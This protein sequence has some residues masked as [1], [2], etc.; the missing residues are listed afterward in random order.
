MKHGIYHLLWLLAVIIFIFVGCENFRLTKTDRGPAIQ[1]HG[2]YSGINYS[3]DMQD[4]IAIVKYYNAAKN[5]KRRC[6]AEKS[7]PDCKIPDRT[8]KSGSGKIFRVEK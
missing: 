2:K 1:A 6:R 8:I 4:I 7:K 3:L 5:I